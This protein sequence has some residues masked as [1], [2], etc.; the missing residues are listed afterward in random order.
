MIHKGIEADRK[1]PGFQTYSDLDELAGTWSEEEAA[2]F[3]DATA[4][5]NQID[6]SLWK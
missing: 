5:F 3:L 2:E 6:H 1:T 4:D